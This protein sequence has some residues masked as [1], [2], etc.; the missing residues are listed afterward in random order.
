MGPNHSW[1]VQWEVFYKTLALYT[2]IKFSGCSFV[3]KLYGALD[4][5]SSDSSSDDQSNSRNVVGSLKS[6]GKMI[7]QKNY[8]GQ[9]LLE[10]IIIIDYFIFSIYL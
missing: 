7:L 9:T 6:D 3:T 4:E 8:Y 10:Y 5:D 2:T 1:T